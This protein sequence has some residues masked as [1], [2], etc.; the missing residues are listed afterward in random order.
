[1]HPKSDAIRSLLEDGSP[2]TASEICIKEQVST[3][4]LEQIMIGLNRSNYH[5]LIGMNEAGDLYY[6]RAGGALPWKGEE[7]F[8]DLSPNFLDTYDRADAY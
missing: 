8:V 4:D 7:S 1:M 2:H 5:I 3:D 6:Q